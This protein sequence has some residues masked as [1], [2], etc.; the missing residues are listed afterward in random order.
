VQRYPAGQPSLLRSINERAVL[1]LIDAAGPVSRVEVAR[2]SG[3]SKPTVSLA[4]SSLVERGVVEEVG[5]LTGRKG[6]AA[7]LYRVNPR[8]GW[9]IGVDLGHERIRVAVCDLSG[10]VKA[11]VEAPVART[12][13]A[14]A[15]RVAELSRRAVD[16]AGLDPTG[17]SQTVIG[18]PAV[19]G[20]DGREL[21]Y[22]EGLPDGGRGL[23]P[24]LAAAVPGPVLLENDVNLA[25][26][27]ERAQG[28]GVGMDDFVLVS[29]G[30]GLGLGVVLG[31]RLHRG[32]SGAAGEAGYLPGRTGPS[33]RAR[34]QPA[35][36]PLETSIGARHIVHLAAD[37]GLPG[38]LTARRVFEL[39]R[40]GD[41]IA[42]GV[43]DDTAAAIAYVI[44]CV[45]PVLDPAL[46]VLGGAIGANPDL[47]E[48]PVARYL[49]DLSPFRP[50]IT[51]STLGS[52][53]VLLGATAM[54][55]ALARETT[56]AA[57]TGSTGEPL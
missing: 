12:C 48:E 40:T 57:S 4:L 50:R 18:V 25:A 32:A 56:F 37:R 24:A 54:A 22:A 30:N 35:H 41:P 42:R 46:V 19:V 38:N 53:A 1:E 20:P 6:P 44:A 23:G 7:A 15:R 45:V 14:L 52:E 21:T 16:E 28:V 11:P 10:Q 3:L 39:A 43:V 51:T 26:L 33:P 34:S 9:S 47:L 2:R 31:G 13:V 29:L 36:P 8:S 5:R 49:A 27:A 55:G 17:V